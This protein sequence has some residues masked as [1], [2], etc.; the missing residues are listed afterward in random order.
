MGEGQPLIIMH[1]VFGSGDNW[2]TLGRKWADEYEV[3]LLDMRNHGK[4]PHS[5]E[6]SYELMADDLLEYLDQ[7]EIEKPLIIGHSMGG[8]V[9]MQF[10]V[11]NDVRVGKLVVADI[12]PK[13]Y[14]PHHDQILDALNDL[15]LDNI[16]SRS[17]AEE[18][19]KIKDEGT[20]QFLLKSLYW[21][22]KGQLAWRFNLPV[23]TREVE[24]VGE[25]LP[26]QAIFQGPTLFVRG[27]KSWYIKDEDMEEIE[28]H[29]PSANLETVEGAGHWLHAEKPKEFYKVVSEFFEK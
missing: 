14:K 28:A 25:A 27:G 22:E 21:K 3:H 4:S 24:K 10:A 26:P 13:P 15:D 20:R 12:A 16:D 11:L 9:G 5:D 18:K 8:K 2:Q 19:F 1:G 7:H 29:F 17:E 6:F 23:I